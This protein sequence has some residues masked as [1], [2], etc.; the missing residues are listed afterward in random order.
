MT[1]FGPLQR[2]QWAT[3]AGQSR[4]LSPTQRFVLAR[5]AAAS[6]MTTLES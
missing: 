6:N 2:D 3:D 5:V 1:A 4:K